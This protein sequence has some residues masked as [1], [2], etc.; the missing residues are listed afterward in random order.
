MAEITTNESGCNNLQKRMAVTYGN[1][2]QHP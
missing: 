1:T 2:K